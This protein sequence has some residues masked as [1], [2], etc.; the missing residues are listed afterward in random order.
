MWFLK[1]KPEAM[2]VEVAND[3]SIHATYG[4][5]RFKEIVGSLEIEWF[6]I[7]YMEFNIFL[8]QV[9]DKL[10]SSFLCLSSSKFDLWK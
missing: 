10:A 1:R 2:A 9:T 3:I 6:L 4:C 7:C 5:N 8:L